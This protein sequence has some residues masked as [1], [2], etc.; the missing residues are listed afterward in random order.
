MFVSWRAA[1]NSKI[2]LGFLL[3]VGS[4]FTIN[5]C[6]KK[7]VRQDNDSLKGFSANLL[8][9]TLSGPSKSGSSSQG[10]N[11]GKGERDY[12]PEELWERVAADKLPNLT[13]DGRMSD[14]KTIVERQIENC[15]EFRRGQFTK[16]PAE[17]NHVRLVCDD[18]TLEELLRLT[19]T[20]QNWESFYANAKKSFDWFKYKVGP[21]NGEPKFTGYNAPMFEASYKQTEKFK[22]PLYARPADLVDIPGQ[23]GKVEWKKRLPDG[24]LVPYDNRKAIDVDRVL[25]GKNLEIAWMEHPVDIWRLQLEGSGVLKII[26]DKGEVK[27]IK[28]VQDVGANYAGNNGLTAISPFKYLKDKGVDNKYL[29]FAG[30]KLYIEENPDEMWPVLTSNPRYVFFSI[31]GEP[32]CATA[33]VY[34]TQGHTLAIDQSFIPFGTVTFFEAMR[35]VEGHDPDAPNAPMKK[36]TRFGIAQDTGGPIKG[37]HFD[38]FW[39]SDDYARLASNSMHS[40][41]SIYIFRKKN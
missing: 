34:L 32:P 38:I 37:A 26:N 33:K 30:L 14:F 7:I 23:D 24:S 1:V 3:L 29:T 40:S 8:E 13:P 19:T 16:C 15:A 9:P 11:H 4:F 25:A 10:K 31:T 35:P 41:G 5:S 12:F 20:S 39:G 22:Y 17:S 28:E 27:E 21:P 2:I 18:A 6:S 36:F